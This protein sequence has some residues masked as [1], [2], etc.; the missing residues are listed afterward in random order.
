MD[1]L[2]KIPGPT[3]VIHASQETFNSMGDWC[4]LHHNASGLIRRSLESTNTVEFAEHEI[5][6]FISDHIPPKSGILAGNSVHF[7]KSFLLKEMPNLI[8]YLDY[9]IVDV[10]SLRQLI[11]SWDINCYNNRPVKTYS[12]RALDDIQE[13]IEELMYYKNCMKFI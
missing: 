4:K 2:E 10:T 11:K 5:L 13:S 3:M 6:N 12:H 9:K 7:D 8:D 1:L